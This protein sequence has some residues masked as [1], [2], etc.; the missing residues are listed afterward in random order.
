[1]IDFVRYKKKMSFNILAKPSIITIINLNN[2]N[3]S[4]PHAIY[5]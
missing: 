2:K 1:M 5:F 4:L 3:M